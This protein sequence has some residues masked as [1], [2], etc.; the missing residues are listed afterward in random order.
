MYGLRE[1]KGD[2]EGAPHKT[3]IAA[4]I[5]LPSAEPRP[6]CTNNGLP[7]RTLLLILGPFPFFSDL[8]LVLCFLSFAKCQL[9][10]SRNALRTAKSHS[11][12]EEVVE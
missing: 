9:S 12:Q 11:L 5:C 1:E 2:A 8:V 7:C 10:S 6:P 3:W 4:T